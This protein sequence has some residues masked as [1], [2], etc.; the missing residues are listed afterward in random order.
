MTVTVI[1][2][3]IMCTG[4]GTV[5][6]SLSHKE[7]GKGKDGDSARQ[8]RKVIQSSLQYLLSE[9]GTQRQSTS[10]PRQNGARLSVTNSGRT[11]GRRLAVKARR[12]PN[13]QATPALVIVLSS[14]ECI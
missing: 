10:V 4:G 9:A 6:R 12:R 8:G 7:S 13:S 1:L 11:S 2:I 5:G 3:V 14:G